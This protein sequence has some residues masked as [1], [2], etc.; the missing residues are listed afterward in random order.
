MWEGVLGTW[1]LLGLLRFLWFLVSFFLCAGEFNCGYL[2]KSMGVASLNTNQCFLCF[3]LCPI[4]SL[5]FFLFVFFFCYNV[6]H[7][8]WMTVVA[9]LRSPPGKSHLICFLPRCHLFHLLTFHRGQSAL[10]AAARRSARLTF[11]S[12]NPRSS[13]VWD[14]TRS[15]ALGI[16]II[17]LHSPILPH[18][19]I[20]PSPETPPLLPSPHGPGEQQH[21]PSPARGDLPG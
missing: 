1:D 18:V 20:A 4:F 2:S 21:S 5:L 9:H 8:W 16:P 7:L 12:P 19:L 6:I 13:A 14:P 15:P 3:Y 17:L 10:P 11:Q